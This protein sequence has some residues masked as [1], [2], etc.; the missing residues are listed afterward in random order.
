MGGSG[1]SFLIGVGLMIVGAVLTN[2]GNNLMSLGHIQQKELD[3]KKAEISARDRSGSLESLVSDSPDVPKLEN[4]PN[5]VKSSQEDAKKGTWLLIGTAIFVVG[6]LISFL[7]FAFAAQSLL[8]A[9]ESTQFVSNVF[10]AKYIHN[11]VITRRIL[12]ATLAIVIGNILVVIF[13]SHASFWMDA[14]D[15]ADVYIHNKAFHIFLI[16]SG[17]MFFVSYGAWYAYYK[18][19]TQMGVF[20]K[21]HCIIESISFISHMS[22]IGAQAVLHSKNLSMIMQHCIESLS[23]PLYKNQ[24]AGLYRFV[25]WGELFGWMLSGYLYVNRINLGLSLYPPVFFI[26]VQAGKK[27]S[28]YIQFNRRLTPKLLKF[29]Q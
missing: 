6:A 17:I 15:I 10:C 21:H 25:T 3:K 27:S 19:R 16:V 24:F 23:N 20:Y 8:A 13:S 14:Q 7:S 4:A 1:N 9:L 5:G 2:V 28:K 29:S 11:E 18:A 26:P 22:L 12:L